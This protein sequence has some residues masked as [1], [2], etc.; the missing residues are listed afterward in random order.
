MSFR[1]SAAATRGVFSR[2]CINRQR[3]SLQ[4][5]VL[6]AT[7]NERDQGR[8]THRGELPAFGRRT[9]AVC[10]S[11]YASSTRPSRGAG[12]ALVVHDMW[13]GGAMQLG[14]WG[15]GTCPILSR[16]FATNYRVHGVDARDFGE[17]V[18][19]ATRLSVFTQL[20]FRIAG[21]QSS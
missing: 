5:H 11:S 14:C 19:G 6:T 17:C 18:S 15:L 12:L 21:K 7:D 3:I 4:T 1:P 20:R 13:V 10:T 16:V 9:I 8:T 2:P